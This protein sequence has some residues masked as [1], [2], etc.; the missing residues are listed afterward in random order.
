MTHRY[1]HISSSSRPVVVAATA[2]PSL[3]PYLL[4]GAVATLILLLGGLSAHAAKPVKL[5][6]SD[7]V[8][9]AYGVADPELG[10]EG[11]RRMAEDKFSG[12]PVEEDGADWM[13]EGEGFIISY[14]GQ[15]PEAEAMVRYV[16]DMVDGYGYIFYFPY[17]ASQREAANK[18]Q[19]KFCSALLD[20]LC[21][22][23]AEMGA[24]PATTELFD[25]DGRLN[26]RD[27]QL[28]LSEDVE[29]KAANHELQ[30]GAIDPDCSGQFI[31]VMSIVPTSTLQ[32]T[33]ELR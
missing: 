9:K 31:L 23:G 8:E 10:R 27:V 5:T 25:V 14:H 29:S 20:E 4:I 19:C 11:C 1:S 17:G 13:S 30:A 2:K 16:N 15:S 18:E 33:A 24:D 21:E 22:M 26:G 3:L 28:T 6:A 12:S 32:Y 7:L